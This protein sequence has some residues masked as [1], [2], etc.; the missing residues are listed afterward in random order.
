MATPAVNPP[1]RGREQILEAVLD[2]AERLFT[3]S[4]PDAVSLRAVATEAG[5]TYSLVNR[6]IGTRE[7]LYDSLI[8]RFEQRWRDRFAA[9][10]ELDE[11]I[12]VLLGETAEVGTYLRLLGWT[13]LGDNGGEAAKTH[14]LHSVLPHLVPLAGDDPA[15]RERVALAVS[16]VFGWR[17]FAGY[18]TEVLG[19]SA[20]ATG[21]VHATVAGVAASLARGDQE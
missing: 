13:V 9:A 5:V 16:L 14:A 1:P 3:S 6:H 2:A 7:A 12:R 19:L 10:T 8:T 11:L 21:R 18:L 4:E 15:A 20:E 17:F